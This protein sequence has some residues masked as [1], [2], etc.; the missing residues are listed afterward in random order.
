MP[1]TTLPPATTEPPTTLPPTT[2][3]PTTLPPTT[4]PPPDRA[5]VPVVVTSAGLDGERVGPTV[6]V[7]ALTGW[8]NIRGVNGVVRLPV[9]TVFYVDGFQNA[10]EQMAADMSLPVTQIAPMSAAPPVAGLGDA[11]LLVYLGDT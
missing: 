11:V 3:P 8:T 6:Y 9:T 5:S 2:L 10:A 4:L 7:L 1:P